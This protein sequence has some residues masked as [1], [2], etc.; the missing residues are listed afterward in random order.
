MNLLNHTVKQQEDLIKVKDFL[1][2]LN[3][4]QSELFNDLY[5]Y[6]NPEF[7]IAE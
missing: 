7:D 4:Y 1:E 2:K 6:I 3:N 5:E